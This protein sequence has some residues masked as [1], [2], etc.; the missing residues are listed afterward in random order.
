DVHAAEDAFQ[1]AF[2]ALARSAR[3]VRQP[4][5][6]SAWLYGTSVRIA[7]SARRVAARARSRES[8]TAERIVIDPP[9]AITGPGLGAAAAEAQ[10]RL[11]EPLRIAIVLCCLEGLSQAEAARRL[12]WSAGSVKGRLERGRERLRQR[13]ARRGI[14]LSSAL[15]LLAVSR[16]AATPSRE[17]IV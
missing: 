7:L 2:L 17:L 8:A 11:S 12:G 15:A 4:A 9:A 10:A 16:A 6:L 5:A 1:A 14:A 13:L 3:R